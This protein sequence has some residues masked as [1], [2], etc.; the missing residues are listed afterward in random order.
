MFTLLLALL[1]CDDQATGT[2]APGPAYSSVYGD[3]PETGRV[4]A[5]TAEDLGEPVAMYIEFES[6]NGWV[7]YG[8]T[9]D[10]NT[11]NVVR[12]E[13]TGLSLNCPSGSF[14]WH[15]SWAR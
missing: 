2:S 5:V 11:A 1:A 8:T 14:G 4:V 6:P 3:C 10:L 9:T 12:T 7:P 15:V 13:E